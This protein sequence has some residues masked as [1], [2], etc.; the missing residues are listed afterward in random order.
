MVVLKN[1]KDYLFLTFRVSKHPEKKYDAILMNKYT[2]QDKIIP[3]G[4]KRYQQYKD[5]TNLGVYNHLNHLDE[6][7]RRLYRLRHAKDIRN[8]FSSGW[9]S[10]YFLW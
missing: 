2:H 4:D 10:Y 3:F 9:F 1:P 7:R 6:N 5:S 8:K